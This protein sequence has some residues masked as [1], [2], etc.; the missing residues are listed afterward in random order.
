MPVNLRARCSRL[1]P[2]LLALPGLKNPEDW[3]SLSSKAIAECQALRNEVLRATPDA[4]VVGLID[5][6]SDVVCQVADPAEFCRSVHPHPEWRKHAERACLNIGAY[7]TQLNADADLLHQLETAMQSRASGEP[8]S[9]EAVSVG[10]RLVTDFQKGGCSQQPNGIDGL[11]RKEQH[12]WMAFDNALLDA[13][14][15]KHLSISSEEY[16]KLDISVKDLFAARPGGTF[17][18]KVQFSNLGSLTCQLPSSHLRKRAY[19]AC[20]NAFPTSVQLLEDLVKVRFDIAKALGYTS[21]AHMVLSDSISGNPGAVKSFLGSVSEGVRDLADRHLHC[22]SKIKGSPL[23]AWDFWYYN[24]QV[25]GNSMGADDLFSFPCI[26][27]GLCQVLQE[28]F[29]IVLREEPMLEGESWSPLVCKMVAEDEKTGILGYVYLDLFDRPD[30]FMG[31]A[32]YTLRCGKRLEGR[33][34]Q[35]PVVAMTMRMSPQQG[36]SFSNLRTFLH[37]FGHALNSLVCR[38]EYQCLFGT[39]G[40]LDLVEIPSHF[41][42]QYAKN[43]ET[44]Q[45]FAGVDWSGRPRSQRELQRLIQKESFGWAT[46]LQEQIQMS[47]VDQELFG[48][49]PFSLGG[50]ANV[51][52]EI[53]NEHG[54][55]PFVKGTHKELWHGHFSG[56]GACYY[57]YSYARCLAAMAWDKHMASNP[58]CRSA[59]EKLKDLLLAPGGASNP[60][61]CVKSLVGESSLKGIEGG[62]APEP[63]KWLEMEAS[64]AS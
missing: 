27:E 47:M 21:Y 28:A 26:I 48:E 2:G 12:V 13:S 41:M 9:T 63:D 31:C 50:S 58:L 6:M 23:D 4:G 30:K 7:I 45:L 5:Q 54:A 34:Y 17:S 25:R 49:E 36:I 32:T 40:P 3:S 62:W 56:Y 61:E 18:A 20:F 64:I 39:R 59:G 33:A 55:L 19:M 10:K 57:S 46:T 14:E 15:R 22:L 51:M 60:Q 16:S 35:I 29:G 8:W 53:V 38:T 44:L 1:V 52:E 42:E 43:P 11:W 24:E 37:E